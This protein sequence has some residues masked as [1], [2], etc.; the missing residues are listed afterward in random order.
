LKYW[1]EKM[2]DL[3]MHTNASDGKLSPQALIDLALEKGLKAIAITDHDTISG[4]VPALEYAKGKGI[5]V[6]PGI[7]INCEEPD[8]RFKEA[9]VIGLFVNHENSALVEFVERAKQDREE[10]KKRIVEKLQG[11]GFDISFEELKASTKDS[12]GRPHIAKLLI[13]KY[14]EKFTSIREVFDKL[15][16]VG[17]PGYAD[18][19]NKSNIKQAIEIVK[20]AGG[21]PILAHPG[22]FS[23]ENALELIKLFQ[24]QGG[25]GIETYYPYHI[26][27]PETEIGEKENTELIK[28][29]QK[30][31]KNFGLLE[32]GGSDFHGRERTALGS[33][34][35][36]DGVL[37][38]M[39]EVL[40]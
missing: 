40:Q 18:R 25:Q 9:E 2:I 10:Q 26:V 24:R 35:V 20:K 1:D 8:P 23:R 11:L 21:L 38:K 7:E 14:P 30:T 37:E 32:S 3:H 6:I 29:F 19:K 36:P 17:K 12:I 15:L 39:K 13:E 27:W 34:N 16:E 22:I 4:I 28:S 5:E 33:M 31:A